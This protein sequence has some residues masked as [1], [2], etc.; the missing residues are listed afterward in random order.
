MIL[1]QAEGATP[2]IIRANKELPTTFC[3]KTREGVMGVLQILGVSEGKASG[4]AQRKI[5]IRYKLLQVHRT[6]KASAALRPSETPSNPAQTYSATRTPASYEADASLNV[7]Q[8][9]DVLTIRATGTLPDQ[10]IDGFYLV[11]SEGS[12]PLGPAYGR[13]DINRLSCEQAEAKITE[14]LQKTLTNP[15]V[16]VTLEKKGNGTWDSNAPTRKPYVIRTGDKL[17]IHA[18]GILADQPIN[19]TYIVEP[20]GTVPLGPSYGRVKVEGMTF[21][22]AEQTIQKKLKED[23]LNP[24]VQV[25]LAG[26]KNAA[27]APSIGREKKIPESG[28]F[29]LE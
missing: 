15:S 1:K 17:F 20:S 19:D 26:W 29:G 25:T 8:P 21:E 4:P 18:V 10:P 24:E 28:K 6:E 23:Y 12:V 7:I 11:E 14:Q 22:A 13:A 2:A 27:D 16:Q 3:F 9:F 5:K